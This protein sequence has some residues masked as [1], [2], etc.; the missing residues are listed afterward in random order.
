MSVVILLENR[1]R[2]RM[3][4]EWR[5]LENEDKNKIFLHLIRFFIALTLQFRHAAFIKPCA[6][7]WRA[8][9]VPALVEIRSDLTS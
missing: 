9:I 6:C 4:E 5:S 1:R 3:T 8:E 7:K 2:L